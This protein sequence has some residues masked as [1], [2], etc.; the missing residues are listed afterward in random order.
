MTIKTRVSNWL[1]IETGV[2][3]FGVQVRLA[4]DVWRHLAEDKTPYLTTDFCAA[5]AKSAE[6]QARLS[7]AALAKGGD[8]ARD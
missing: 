1:N 6:V 2:H 7:A 3:E 8:H 5:E 4:G